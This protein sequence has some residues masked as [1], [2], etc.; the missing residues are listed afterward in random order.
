MVK[1][2]FSNITDGSEIMCVSNLMIDVLLCVILTI[3]PVIGRLCKSSWISLN[4]PTCTGAIPVKT[5]PLIFVW[6]G[7]GISPRSMWLPLWWVS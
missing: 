3:D 1:S 7:S 5:W 4:A 6:I 2:S